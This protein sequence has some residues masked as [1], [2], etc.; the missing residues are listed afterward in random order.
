MQVSLV[1]VEYIENVWPSIE[2]YLD[3]AA[4]YTYGRFTVAD[5]KNGIMTT[6]QQLWIAFDGDDVYGAV[7]TEVCVYP[8]M[9]TLIMHF[10]GGKQ[11]PK[12]KTEMLELLQRFAKDNGCTTIESYGRRGWEKVFKNDGFKSR[13]MF[14]ELPV[15]GK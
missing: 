1:P 8:Q 3:G 5:I 14:Y 13:F 11:L 15:E 4:T 10:T 6:P 7:V 9:S 12:W 2:A